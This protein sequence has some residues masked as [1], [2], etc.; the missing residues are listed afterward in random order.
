M[1]CH[2]RQRHPQNLVSLKPGEERS[3]TIYLQPA[4]SIEEIKPLLAASLSAPMIDADRYTL[5]SRRKQQPHVL[6]AQAHHSD[7]QRRRW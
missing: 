2:C 3:W 4:G 7:G 1:R 5:G 6:G